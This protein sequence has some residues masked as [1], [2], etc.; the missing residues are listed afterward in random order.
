MP[1]SWTSA[2]EL[3]GRWTPAPR[4]EH[5]S[6]EELVGEARPERRTAEPSEP[7]AE[8]SDAPVPK[9]GSAE[10]EARESPS[11]RTG[12]REQLF[13][14]PWPAYGVLRFSPHEGLRIEAFGPSGDLFAPQTSFALWGE[15]LDGTPCSL[16]PAWISHEHGTLGGHAKRDVTG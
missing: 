1:L 10:A 9:P 5:E 2:W 14:D 8:A 4:S 13:P 6:V 15:T 3:P 16:L 12:E 11:P 7:E